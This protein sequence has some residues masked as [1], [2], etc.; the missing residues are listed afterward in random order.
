MYLGSKELTSLSMRT[1]QQTLQEL[2]SK[3]PAA[4]H[5]SN[6]ARQDLAVDIRRSIFNVDL[7]YLG[8][9]MPLY[10]RIVTQ[11]L[12]SSAPNEGCDNSTER[13][14]RGVLLEQAERGVIAAKHSARILGLLPAEYGA[15]KRFWL[16]M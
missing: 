9:I 13:P 5:L 1:V 8:T 6:L 2:H 7:L 12:Q 14:S 16:V 4:M 11:L 3:L 10:R 15:L